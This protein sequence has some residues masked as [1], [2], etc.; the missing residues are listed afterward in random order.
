MCELT[1]QACLKRKNVSPAHTGECMQATSECQLMCTREYNPVCGSDGAT[2]GNPCE[3]TS[4][5]CIKRS[6][7][8]QAH[9]GECEKTCQVLCN[10]NYTPVCGTDNVTYGNVCELESK[11]CLRKK[12][13][14]VAKN[15]QC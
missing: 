3:L 14:R 8:I 2:Y 11:A 4:Q 10:L 5:A 1:S 7:V 9:S 12:D 15:G 13:V 6:G